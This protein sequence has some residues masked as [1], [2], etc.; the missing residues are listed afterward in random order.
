VKNI[1]EPVSVYRV[2][3]DGVK[4][5]K[6]P[7]RKSAR[8]WRWVIAGVAALALVAGALF[9]TM[10][11]DIR[12][13]TPG[14]KPGVAVL[15]FANIAG[16]EEGG[17]LADGITEDIIT[18]LSR[19]K[20]FEVI[21]R[22]S[23]EV[24]KGKPADIRQVGHDLGVSYVLEGSIQLQADRVRV[25]GELIDA[26]SGSHVWANRWDRSAADLFKVQSEISEAVA[27]ALGGSFNM[28][29]I[30]QRETERTGRKPPASLDAYDLYLIGVEAKAQ[31][32]KESISKGLAALDQSIALDPNFARAYIIRGWLHMFTADAGVPWK[33]ALRAMGADLKK[34]VELDPGD[35]DAQAA[36]AYYH[37][38]DNKLAESESLIREA[39]ALNPNNVNVL[40][41]AAMVLPY[42][43]HPEEAATLADRA[44]RLDPRMVPANLAGMRH[45]YYWSRHFEQVIAVMNRIPEESRSSLGLL[46]LAASYA[47]L[48]RADEAAAAKRHY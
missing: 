24:Y 28:G 14:G 27:G 35:A 21:A 3:L 18:D 31:R 22:N 44:L 1:T 37:T 9:W 19:F 15:P 41:L 8:P 23:T 5:L 46:Q 11:E 40:G 25:T 36:L 20:D 13:R 34:G 12:V 43:G 17:R 45:A 33:V 2:R 16:S 10:H 47:F 38:M 26:E 6:R 30:M 48:G 39:L 7:R 29:A 32:T 42:V 4:Q